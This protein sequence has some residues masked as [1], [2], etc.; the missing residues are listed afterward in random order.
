MTLSEPVLLAVYLITY[1]AHFAEEFWCGG[2]YPAYLFRLRGIVLPPRRFV[3]LQALGFLLL[4]VSAV[5]SVTLH[6][7]QFALIA[8][9]GLAVT[10]GITHTATAIWDRQYG[11]GLIMSVLWIPLG[12]ATTTMFYG[13]MSFARFLG[14]VMIGTAVQFVIAG[15]T[16]MGRRERSA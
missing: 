13:N 6:F 11:P 5:V 4:L 12:L 7:P 16:L 3:L 15:G 10:N 8:F 2:G 1:I 9:A 14:G